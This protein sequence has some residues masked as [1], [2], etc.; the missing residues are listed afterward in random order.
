SIDSLKKLKVSLA[1]QMDMELSNQLHYISLPDSVWNKIALPPL[2][3]KKFTD[4]LPDSARYAVYNTAI[5]MAG[6]L[7]NTL[8]FTGSELENKKKEIRYNDIE[9]H[10]KFSLSLACVVLFF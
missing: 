9:W 5:S 1:K 6:N 3:A 4:L 2:Q 7:K 10:R 8:Q